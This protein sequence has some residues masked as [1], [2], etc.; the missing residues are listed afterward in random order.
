MLTARQ[1]VRLLRSRGA[2]ASLRDSEGR[3]MPAL[4]QVVTLPLRYGH[5]PVTVIVTLPALAQVVT[6]PLRYG[7]ITAAL[8]ALAQV[9]TLPS[10]YRYIAV[11]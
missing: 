8:P 10:H 2:D 7:Y 3:D 11:S 1:M 4:A 9:V 5:M 6:L